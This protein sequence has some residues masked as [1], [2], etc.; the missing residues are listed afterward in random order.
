MPCTSPLNAYML[1][2]KVIVGKKG[3]DGFRLPCNR[4]MACRVRRTRDWAIRVMHEAQMSDQNS[5]LTLTYNDKEADKLP[6]QSGL[7][8]THWQKFAKRLRHH[9]KFRFLACGEYTEKGRAHFHA[10]VLSHSFAHD[11]YP[12]K[13]TKQGH[14]LYR[15]PTLESLWKH[16]YSWIGSLSF[17]S[18]AYV[19]G[20]VTKKVIGAQQD[21]D[22]LNKYLRVDKYTGEV[23]YVRREF[24]IMSRNPG[25]GKPFFDEFHHDL[26][27]RDYCVINGAKVQVPRYYD[28]W[29]QRTNPYMYW[30]IKN[31]RKDRAYDLE[32]EVLEAHE[33][34]LISKRALLMDREYDPDEG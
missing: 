31:K 16:G 17:D 33:A 27:P 5:F 19:A 3:I 15:S 11:R 28:S 20:Y 7:D 25:L 23:G 4:C 22:Y 10:A 32:P 26:Y 21:Q 24:A 2:G 1:N 6:F 18:A 13:R 9:G 14:W 29:L 34:T 8:V 30:Y 12:W